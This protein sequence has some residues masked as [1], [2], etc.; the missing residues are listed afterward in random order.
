MKSLHWTKYSSKNVKNCQKFKSPFITFIF[1]MKNSFPSE[2][3]V[4]IFF[5]ILVNSVSKNTFL[6]WNR[7]PWKLTSELHLEGIP[8]SAVFYEVIQC[9]NSFPADKRKKRSLHSFNVDSMGNHPILQQ[10]SFEVPMLP[11][12]VP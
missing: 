9:C 2:L 3:G 1:A 8:K 12:L 5:T 11:C 6:H 7:I 10:N 4:S